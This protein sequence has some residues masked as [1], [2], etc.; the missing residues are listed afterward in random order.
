[1]HDFSITSQNFSHLSSINQLYINYLPNVQAA[2]L[3]SS[4]I[5]TKNTHW[6]DVKTQNRASIFCIINQY[7]QIKAGRTMLSTSCQHQ[8]C[9]HYRHRVLYFILLWIPSCWDYLLL[10]FTV[11]ET[12]AQELNAL[13]VIVQMCF[14]LPW[15]DSE[16][17]WIMQNIVCEEYRGKIK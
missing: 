6:R 13:L 9:Q 12:E 17:M 4:K 11:E 10:H 16:R 14:T 1:M 8:L 2:V 3:S 15:I 5:R 7:I